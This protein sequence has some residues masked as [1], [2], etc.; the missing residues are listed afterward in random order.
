LGPGGRQDPA[1][2]RH[3]QAEVDV[4]NVASFFAGYSAKRADE[5]VEAIA[6]IVD[7]EG[8]A[9]SLRFVV[10][11]QAG[12]ATIANASQLDLYGVQEEAYAAESPDES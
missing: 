3:T 9:A 5:R 8:S 4:G 2:Q 12:K 1:R 6:L 11:D 7:G 10:V